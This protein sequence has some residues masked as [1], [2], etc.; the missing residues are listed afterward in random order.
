M[1]VN[2]SG[3]KRPTK[4]GKKDTVRKGDR[5]RRGLEKLREARRHQKSGEVAKQEPAR[6]R[7]R[8]TALDRELDETK[9][10]PASARESVRKSASAARAVT[11][12]APM[13]LGGPDHDGGDRRLEELA[14][15][16][17]A[18]QPDA[19]DRGLKELAETHGTPIPQEQIADVAAGDR[20]LLALA[21]GGSVPSEALFQQK[22]R[23]LTAVQDDPVRYLETARAWP[24]V[25]LNGLEPKERQE[26]LTL[27]T[28]SNGT[29]V[30]EVKGTRE[31]FEKNGITY[32]RETRDDGKVST[33]YRKDG[34]LYHTYQDSD[35]TGWS[36]ITLD[37]KDK[38]ANRTVRYDKDGKPLSDQSSYTD[39]RDSI[40][41][42]D[43]ARALERTDNPKEVVDDQL[44]AVLKGLNEDGIKPAQVT[45][46]V[47]RLVD[48]AHEN[49]EL[50]QQI[51][52]EMAELPPHQLDAT[53]KA[54]AD[55]SLDGK[56]GLAEEF[57][58]ILEKRDEKKRDEFEAS[59]PKGGDADPPEYQPDPNVGKFRAAADLGT[60]VE[61]IE[62]LLAEED[63]DLD[64]AGRA[65]DSLGENLEHATPEIAQA[66]MKKLESNGS[67]AQFSTILRDN[68][69]DGIDGERNFYTGRPVATHNPLEPL[70][71][72]GVEDWHRFDRVLGTLSQAVV[73]A[74][75]DGVTQSV[76]NHIADAAQDKLGR[77]D[78]A[79]E[80]TIANGG[81]LRLTAEVA[82]EL[83]QRDKTEL[84]ESF[85]ST[86]EIGIDMYQDHFSET[87][88]SV[89]S[90]DAELSYHL[91]QWASFYG[92][93]EEGQ[94]AL[95]ISK[96]QFR[97]GHPEYAQL[98][99]LSGSMGDDLEVLRDLNQ[100]F[101]RSTLREQE[102]ELLKEVPRMALSEAGQR[103]IAEA[104]ERQGHSGESSFL[105]RLSDSDF[106]ETLDQDYFEELGLEDEAAWEAAMGQQILTSSLALTVEKA[107]Q[108]DF[109][110][111]SDLG[112]GLEAYHDLIGEKPEDLRAAIDSN[113]S[114]LSEALE[115][116]QKGTG[117]AG[118][119]SEFLEKKLKESPGGLSDTTA[120]KFRVAGIGL[121]TLGVGLSWGAFATKDTTSAKDAM[122]VTLDTLD[123]VVSVTGATKAGKAVLGEHFLDG[124]SKAFAGIGATIDG[125]SALHSLSNREY[126]QAAFSGMSA[127]GGVV[128]LAGAT[129]I[130]AVISLSAA[131]AAYQYAR[132]KASNK[133]EESE[134]TEV[135]LRGALEANGITGDKQDTAYKELRNADSGGR[136]VGVL[137]DQTAKQLGV[138]PGSLLKTLADQPKDVLL[139][140]VEAGHG[141]DPVDSDDLTSLPLSDP[142]ANRV[143]QTKD[144]YLEDKRLF[145]DEARRYWESVEYGREEGISEENLEQV[146]ILAQDQEMYA[147]GLPV[148]RP[149]SVGGFATYLRNL[150]LYPHLDPRART[151]NIPNS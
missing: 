20:R 4:V 102:L 139:D 99:A 84:S 28:Y 26:N 73:L 135:F 40:P 122:M 148:Y 150:G 144:E 9:R 151:G 120:S 77:F 33:Y 60:T 105:D 22:D 124:T 79:L 91:A 134:Y 27:S 138:E 89:Q 25:D 114:L 106:R 58:S 13:Y 23:A 59:I 83:K 130:G 8:S 6:H 57:A 42:A 54:F 119:F 69:T 32:T 65:A 51:A 92:D 24:P 47:T 85:L 125:L 121:S 17:K 143:G 37:S 127:V 15:E 29:E 110:A 34:A 93:D 82:K 56:S 44:P 113:E 90:A 2:D 61:E 132:V 104:V 96:A 49:P 21:N 136:N 7:D 67:L 123:G 35:G 101:D 103:G 62:T 81:G 109:D 108:G 86:A 98:E 64:Q 147:A 128:A 112:D 3:G 146:I 41:P 14:E 11:N 70:P 45:S 1:R 133:M 137:L 142:N 16:L 18:D 94:K 140:I 88:D 117:V 116:G 53:L 78:E 10:D 126:A 76:A 68:N 149:E 145:L 75:D 36:S 46:T 38:H 118:E 66:L 31:T 30:T 55:A 97:A 50:T 129:G 115:V 71:K 87:A 95:E 63:A 43:F 5:L 48:L 107:Q 52:K 74:E 72:Q 39:K 12:S 80:L 131:A 111:V 100:T 141:V 19:G